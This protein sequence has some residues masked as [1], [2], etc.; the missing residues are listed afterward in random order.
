MIWMKQ[1]AYAAS[2]QVLIFQNI[3]THIEG[4]DLKMIKSKFIQIKKNKKQ[5]N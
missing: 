2:E 4:N 5:E 1:E 3:Q